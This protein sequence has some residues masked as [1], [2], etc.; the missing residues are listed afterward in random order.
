MQVE[1]LKSKFKKFK[2]FD[3]HCHAY[4]YSEKDIENFIENKI[5]IFS[6]SEDFESIQ[7]NIEISKKFNIPFFIGIHPWN[8]HKVSKSEIK[9]LEEIAKN[10]NCIGI[11][12]IGLDKVF[13]SKT[14]ETQKEIFI[15]QL[16]IAKEFDLPINIHS[17]GTLKE[18]LDLVI[19]FDIK[20]ANFHWIKYSKYVE[21]I[22]NLGYFCSFNINVR[23]EENHRKCLEVLDLKNILTESDGP[24]KYKNLEMKSLDVIEVIKEISNFYNVGENKILKQ[25]KRNTKRFIKL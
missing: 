2:Y 25:I 23:Y 3:I 11:G 12:E 13:F 18:V 8:S 19:K 15:E 5:L 22:K 16:K 20:N 17:L 1:Q 14:L 10:Y 4:E 21:E 24:Y 7:K 6:V 9:K